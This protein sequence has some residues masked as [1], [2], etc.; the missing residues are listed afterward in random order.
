MDTY[1]LTS[2]QDNVT[3]EYRQVGY[4]GV[5]GIA[6]QFT[7]I[8]ILAG[9]TG[10]MGIAFFFLA[11]GMGKLPADFSVGTSEIV[12][13]LLAFMLTAIAQEGMHVLILRRYG[14]RPRFGIMR[15]SGLPY[16]SIP[17]YGL[18]RNALIVTA[19]TPLV[20][21]TALSLLGIWLFQGTPWVALFAL[22]AVVNAA[23]S[24]SDLLFTALLLRYPSTAWIADDGHGMRVLMPME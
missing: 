16:L 15:N 14:A 6:S 22:I 7:Q 3:G 2:A 18:R 19:L 8:G 4:I 24:S 9:V 5:E 17:D 21:L 20:V 1:R 12:I 23:A 11:R 13:G 10:L